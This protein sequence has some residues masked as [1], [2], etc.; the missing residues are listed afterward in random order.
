MTTSSAWWG[1]RPSWVREVV[2]VSANRSN[3]SQG[4]CS[5]LGNKRL[6]VL[7]DASISPWAIVRLRGFCG[8]GMAASPAR[9][10]RRRR[11]SFVAS[12]EELPAPK[13]LCRRS[14]ALIGIG[15]PKLERV[16]KIDPASPA[17]FRESGHERS[18]RVEI[19]EPCK[20][21][22]KVRSIEALRHRFGHAPPRIERAREHLLDPCLA[23]HLRDFARRPAAG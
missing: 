19:A 2:I 9:G 6:V 15:H 4:A 17:R 14:E 7:S 22:R 1:W 8:L 13:S 10:K 12:E 16:S 11:I 23:E 3:G 20:V 21:D 5:R 18:D